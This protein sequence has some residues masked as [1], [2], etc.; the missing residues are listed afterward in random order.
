[1]Q[2]DYTTAFAT[3]SQTGDSTYYSSLTPGTWSGLIEVQTDHSGAMFDLN[4]MYVL[5][6]H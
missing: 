1:M 2:P 4:T 3:G 6:P 5:V